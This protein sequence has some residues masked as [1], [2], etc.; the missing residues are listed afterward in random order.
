M[1]HI[2]IYSFLIL[3]FA[4]VGIS[5]AQNV[6]VGTTTPQNKLHVK[7]QMRVDT[8]TSGTLIADSIVLVGTNGLFKKAQYNAVADQ[9]LGSISAFA[10]SAVPAD[11]LECNGAAVSRTTYAAL[12]AKIGTTFGAGN[13]S[14]TFNV[15]DLRGEFIRGWSNGRAGVDVGRTM[16]SSQLDQFQGH[17]VSLQYNANKP[18]A[19]GSTVQDF[20]SNPGTGTL[21][22]NAIGLITDGVNGAPRVGS[23][24]RPRNVAMV[25]AI[26]AKESVLVP[27]ATSTAVTTAAI[28]NEPWFN[29]ATGT[30]ATANT[31][32]IYQMGKVGIGIATPATDAVLE[33]SSAN[34][35]L[36][37]TR[38]ATT[39]AIANPVNGMIIYDIS[40]NCVKA[41]ENGAWSA[42]LSAG[43][44]TN[45]ATVAIDCSNSSFSCGP[46]YVGTTGISVTF[47]VT[48][49]SFSNVSAVDFSNAVT[50]SGAGAAGLTVT[51]GQNSS[52]SINSGATATL[53]YNLA[54]SPT[55]AGTLTAAFTKLGLSCTANSV[56]YG[57]SGGNGLDGTTAANANL[58]CSAIKQAFPASAD[59]VYWIDPDLNCT[60]LSAM[61]VQCDMTTAGG[62]WTKIAAGG[63]A[64][65]GTFSQTT[66]ISNLTAGGYWPNNVA[67]KFGEMSIT[68]IRIT[69][70]S[71]F[72]NANIR[73]WDLGDAIFTGTNVANWLKS[74]GTVPVTSLAAGWTGRFWNTFLFDGYANVHNFRY[75]SL[76][77]SLSNTMSPALCGN[78]WRADL[79]DPSVNACANVNN[80]Y[81]W[82]TNL[83]GASYTCSTP[84]IRGV[85][86]YWVR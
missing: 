4:I 59:G 14:T 51:A 18:Y 21:A 19:P 13:G 38:V 26:K 11:Y 35:S 56:V 16:G 77:M 52:I 76:F 83:A 22:G 34:K 47:L 58:S 69:Q 75:P 82:S 7:G 68:A 36:L 37:L 8:L 27:T 84:V 71:T 1:N 81:I 46:K 33:L 17:N 64:S 49:N 53:T 10:F 70:A 62:G 25:Y 24:T 79:F 23:E 39:G 31:Q 6:G 9:S 43:S 41:Y 28:A 57:V 67:F 66:S 2:K 80:N 72:A 78:V 65:T 73:N 15:P 32:D 20:F 3:C 42:C 85:R 44:S 50:L 74:T 55:T 29:V 40:S 48:N 63:D 61:Q 30:A 86:V 12:F 45:S 54:G 60:T 5:R